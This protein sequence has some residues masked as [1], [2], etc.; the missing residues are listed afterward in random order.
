MR[1]S[2]IRSRDFISVKKRRLFKVHE[3]T[4]R[5]RD[6]PE[7]NRFEQQGTVVLQNYTRLFAG[8]TELVL[9]G[10]TSRA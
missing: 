4:Q 6:M 3:G 5:R 2:K 1:L 10:A 9:L 7:R 8:S